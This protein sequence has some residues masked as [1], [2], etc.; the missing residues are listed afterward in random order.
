MISDCEMILVYM[1]AIERELYNLADAEWRG[2]AADEL[3]YHR[4]RVAQ[5]VE[6]FVAEE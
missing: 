2:A 1:R 4:A 6:K 5:W 3:A